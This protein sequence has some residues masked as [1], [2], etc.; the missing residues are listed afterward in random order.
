MA[1]R[2]RFLFVNIGSMKGSAHCADPRGMLKIAETPAEGISSVE[3]G[4]DPAVPYHPQHVTAATAIEQRL[5][6]VLRVDWGRR[7]DLATFWS[8]TTILVLTEFDRTVR[9]N[10]AAATDHGTGPVAFLAAGAVAGGWV[11]ADLPGLAAGQS[12]A[13]RDLQPT[14]DIRAVATGPG[15]GPYVSPAP[16]YYRVFRR[17]DPQQ[18]RD[19]RGR[20]VL[21][22]KASSAGRAA[23]IAAVSP[24]E[25]SALPGSLCGP[26]RTS[27]VR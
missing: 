9:V 3:P 17:G 21:R 1:S 25:F 24:R 16:G 7:A 23:V 11:L 2:N 19:R 20:P 10:S 27:K 18:R 4:Y 14:L 26:C 13:N 6:A 22:H 8:K 12:F 15:S 5:A